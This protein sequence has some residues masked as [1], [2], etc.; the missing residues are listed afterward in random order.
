LFLLHPDPWPKNRHHKRRFVQTETL[1]EMARL[2]KPGAEFRTATDHQDLAAWLL[3]K[4][5]AHLA[6]ERVDG[7][8]D[9][10]PETRYGQK[11]VRQGRPPVY[12]TFKKKRR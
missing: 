4:T 8:A 9:D 11:G 6:F 3:E 10:W 1:D 12:L 2:L 5:N 7:V